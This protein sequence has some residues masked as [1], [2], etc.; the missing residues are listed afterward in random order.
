M[1][2]TT[3]IRTRSR[4]T[5]TRSPFTQLTFRV[6]H[7]VGDGLRG[8]KV[9]DRAVE[10]PAPAGPEGT[11]AEDGGGGHGSGTERS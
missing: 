1:T 8:K 4:S 3:S 2:S 6:L 7:R 11:F 9:P 10:R 5:A